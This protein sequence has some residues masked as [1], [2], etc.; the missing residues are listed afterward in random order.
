MADAV[1]EMA[2][3]LD[4]N[5]SRLITVIELCEQDLRSLLKIW[6]GKDPVPEGRIEGVLDLMENLREQLSRSTDDPLD[7]ASAARIERLVRVLES[8][9]GMAKDQ[10]LRTS[11]DVEATRLR[12]GLFSLGIELDH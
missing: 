4:E 5:K 8:T 3:Q 7:P 12:T 2:Q 1:I 9:A 10:Q 6:R 11:I